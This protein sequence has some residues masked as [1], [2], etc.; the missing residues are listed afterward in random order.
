[1][2]PLRYDPDLLLPDPRLRARRRALSPVARASLA[3]SLAGN[4]NTHV[5]YAV[6]RGEAPPAPDPMAPDAVPVAREMPA[7]E[8]VRQIAPDGT[9]PVAFGRLTVPVPL[10]P[11]A[12][13]ILGLIDGERSVGE[14]AGALAG[15]G[16]PRARFETVWP[17]T[18]RALSRANRVLARTVES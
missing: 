5:A 9:L 11:Q 2:E 7:A 12:R 16:I 18:Y 6:R 14:I 17:E 15:R 13:A 3:E 1:M 8:L 4:M 10:P